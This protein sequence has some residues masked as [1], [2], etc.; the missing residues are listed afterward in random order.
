MKVQRNAIRLITVNEAFI[1]AE[2]G[3]TK[4]WYEVNKKDQFWNRGWL[5]C[6]ADHL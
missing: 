6:V 1:N 5:D 4:R 2:S 3:L